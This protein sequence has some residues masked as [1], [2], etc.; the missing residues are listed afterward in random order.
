MGYFCQQKTFCRELFKYDK[1]SSSIATISNERNPFFSQNR[2]SV[3]GLLTR[4]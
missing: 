3:I 4:A 2:V 1:N